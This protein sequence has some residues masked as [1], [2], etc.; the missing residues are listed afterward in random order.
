MLS[1]AFSAAVPMVVRSA[2]SEKRQ[3]RA[4]DITSICG[5]TVKAYDL[6]SGLMQIS[7]LHG[8]SAAIYSS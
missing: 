5:C 3:L 6:R 7:C 4:P 2:S 8:G 1:T